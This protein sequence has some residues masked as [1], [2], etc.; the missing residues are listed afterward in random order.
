MDATVLHHRYAPRGACAAAFVSRRPEILLSGPAGTGKSRAL[1]ERLHL[2]AL[3]NP[4]L[5]GLIVRKTLASL[6]STALVTWNRFVVPEARAAG[7]VAWYGGSQQESPQYR[8]R[9]GSSIGVGGLDRATRIMS[10]EYDVVYVQEAIELTEPDWEAITTRLR[11]GRISFQQ[12]MGDTNPDTPTHWLNKRCQRGTCHMYDSRHEDNPLLYSEAGQLTE[13]GRAYLGKLDALTGPRHARL[14]HGLWVAAEGQ[15][16]DG[17]DTAVHLVDRFEIPPEWPRYWAVDF[18]YTNPMVIQWWAVDPDGRLY[19]YREVYHTRRT[20]D[21][22]ARLALSLVTDGRGRWTEPRPRAIVCDH[23]AEGRAVLERELG[24]GTVAARKTVTDGI[25]AIQERLVPA[26]DGRPRIY[27]LRDSLVE[28]DPELT[29][30]RKPCCTAEELPGY[31]WDA[32]KE[33]PVKNDDHGCD[34][35][36]YMVAEVDL[37]PRPRI[38]IMS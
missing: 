36:R 6:G 24:M 20:V 5:R 31:V 9:N 37:Q 32:M 29:D 19:L 35:A 25:Q 10:S 14:R 21:A 12:I 16:Y 17:Y 22:H 27:L 15:I 33:K 1:L 4:G 30:A 26:G 8:Y 18:G 28:R 3:I 2:L 7:D 13:V 23:D 38:R 11:N 34:A